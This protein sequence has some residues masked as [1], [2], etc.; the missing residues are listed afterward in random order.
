MTHRTNNYYYQLKYIYS[1]IRFSYIVCLMKKLMMKTLLNIPA[2]KPP[3]W[4][5]RQAGRYLPEY[6]VL[7]KETGG[8]LTMCYTP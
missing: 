7:R 3:I 8:F 4:F 1:F 2:D 6:R 5:M